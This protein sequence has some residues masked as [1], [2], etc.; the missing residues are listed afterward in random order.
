[1]N[2]CCTLP[3]E[4]IASDQHK[5]EDACCLITEKTVAPDRAECP[6]SKTTSRKVQHRTVEHLVK[7]E[8]RALIADVQYYFCAEPTCNVV[9]FSTQDSTAFTK[10][11]ILVKVFSKDSSDD[12]N[13]CY[14]FDWT[15]GK[16]KEQINKTG[17]STASVEIAKEV[18]AGRCLC[19]VKNPKGECCLGDVNRVVK[20]AKFS[21]EELR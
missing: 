11:D 9:Y 1:M 7:P 17:R 15:R 14:C 19:D 8:K 21:R 18:K 2:S 20:E 16:I 4:T 10:A 6:V 12:V 3:I 5:T 13:V